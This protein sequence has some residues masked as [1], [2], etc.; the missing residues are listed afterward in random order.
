MKRRV[1]VTQSESP[2]APAGS[3]A[4]ADPESVRPTSPPPRTAGTPQRRARWWPWL[5][6]VGVAYLVLLPIGSLLF[7]AIQTDVPGSP[8]AEFTAQWF[9]ESYWGALTGGP[10]QHVLW[11]SIAVAVPSTILATGLGTV[12]AWLL[13]RTN[14]RAR[15]FFEYGLMVPMFYSPLVG[16]IG[17]TILGAPGAGWVNHFWQWL[18]G[19][20]GDLVNIYSSGGIV[21]ALTLFYLPYGIMMNT[22]AF[23]SM[24]A[25]QEEAAAVSGAGRWRVLRTVTLPLLRPS[26]FASAIFIFIFCLEQFSIPGA[27]GSQSQYETLAY[28]IYLNVTKYPTNLG[29]AAAQG[30]LLLVLTLITLGFYRRMLKKAARFVTV[31]GKGQKAST[32][33]LG[34]WRWAAAVGCALVFVVGTFLPLATIL[35]RAL[36]ATR[37]IGIDWAGLSM[38]GFADLLA[39]PDFAESLWN[40]V[41]LSVGAA[42]VAVIIGLVIAVSTVRTRPHP[43]TTIADYLISMPVALPGTVFGIGL[44]WAYIGS[45]LYQTVALML[46]AFVTRYTIFSVRMLTAGLVQIDPALQE[47]AMVAGARKSKAATLIELPLL[48]GAMASAWLLIFLSVMRELATAIMVY[49][50][51]S[52]TLSILTWNYMEDGFFGVASALAVAQVVIV[53]AIVGVIM[54]LFRGRIRLAEVAGGN[55]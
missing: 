30:T 33:R 44:V 31:G 46:L 41:V 54:L 14:M 52:R 17:W 12:L 51:G 11:N 6:M 34:R 43:G 38:G 19:S 13:T 39:A 29:L 22:A 28:S 9:I 3:T 18:T 7:G 45:P 49:G 16:I 50:V 20:S 32:I 55:A 48:K 10:M 4:L 42:V 37:E 35:L 53:G 25:T 21:F 24:D 26:I 1:L 2:A 27:L 15:R 8:D 23:R 36:M 47:A 5:L 40:S